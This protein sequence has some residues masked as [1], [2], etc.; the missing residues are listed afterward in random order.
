MSTVSNLVNDVI[1]SPLGEV[2]AAVGQGVADAQQALDEGSL[3]KVLEIYSEGGESVLQLL[4][5]IGYT[6]TFY[7]LPETIGEIKVALKLNGNQQTNGLAMRTTNNLINANLERTGLNIPGLKPKMYATPVDAGYAN[8]YGYQADVSAKLTF[9]IVPVPAPSGTEDLRLLPDLVGTTIA[10]AQQTLLSLN[11]IIQ[12]VDEQGAS[13]D[14]GA[15]WVITAQN[16]TY[17]NLTPTIVRAGDSVTI[18]A[19]HPS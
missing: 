1:S 17:S 9:K 11:L 3:A 6:P 19:A 5:D 7:T 14:A 18:T 13:S 2:I 16:P 10:Q 8:R 4:R 12:I 15:E